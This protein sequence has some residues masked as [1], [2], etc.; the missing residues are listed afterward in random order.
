[1][2]AQRLEQNGR[3]S[4]ATC[5]L[6]TGHLAATRTA[7]RGG[8]GRSG[9]VI[10]REIWPRRRDPSTRWPRKRGRHRCRRRPLFLIRETCSDA[11]GIADRV[12]ASAHLHVALVAV[13]R[14]IEQLVQE[15]LD[16]GLLTLFR[17]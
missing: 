8:V 1:M 4:A 10:A 5:L 11:L 17:L 15:V 16:D 2:S 12:S 13:E 7:R 9:G 6:Q 3:Y 14:L